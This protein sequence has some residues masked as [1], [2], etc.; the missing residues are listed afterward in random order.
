MNTSEIRAELERRLE[1]SQRVSENVRIGTSDAHRYLEH[2]PQIKCAD[3]FKLSVQASNMHYCNPRNS[4]GPW[5]L[6]EV[7]FPSRKVTSFL[8]YIDGGK[9]T[10][11]TKTVYGFV[12]IDLVVQAIADHGGFAAAQVSA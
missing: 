8:P 4:I 3:G 2:V 12:P 6:V 9:H 7:G 10:A 1:P 11:P 5:S